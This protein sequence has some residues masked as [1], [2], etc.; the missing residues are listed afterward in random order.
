M[1]VDFELYAFLTECGEIQNKKSLKIKNTKS[2]MLSSE[3]VEKFKNAEMNN[4]II[5]MDN[6][7]GK[8]YKSDYNYAS[9]LSELKND[10]KS[11][12][13]TRLYNWKILANVLGCFGL[14]VEEDQYLKI[15]GGNYI[16]L[17]EVLTTIYNFCSELSKR[18]N[19]LNIDK[20]TD[21]SII[22]TEKINTKIDEIQEKNKKI[23]TT[24]NTYIQHT[25]NL[26]NTSN[27]RR[28]EN[29]VIE[30]N[31]LNENKDIL[32]SES[33]LEYF[34]LS[35]CKS[36]NIKIRQAAG[37]LS[38]NRKFLIQ[39]CNKG[40]KGDYSKL[41]NWYTILNKTTHCLLVLIKLSK[42]DAK[43]M[44]YAT[45]SCGLYSK[46][47]AIA[48]NALNLLNYL[49]ESTEPET[50][51]FFKE[52]LNSYL[53][54]INY[55][56][57]S[58]LVK[59][60]NS[61]E[62]YSK[63]NLQH[64][65]NEIESKFKN[66]K[67]NLYNF[68]ENI[69]EKI[70]CC[71]DNT[72]NIFKKFIFNNT[73]D[74]N[75]EDKARLISIMSD[76]WILHYNSDIPLN[77]K[78][79]IKDNLLECLNINNPLN[80]NIN[81]YNSKIVQSVA[82][83]Q[84]FRLISF[85]G[86]KKDPNAPELLKSVN[87]KLI[88]NFK[89]DYLREQLL[90]NLSIIFEQNKLIPVDI[91]FIDYI[92]EA[93]SLENLDKLKLFDFKFI[94]KM[95][96]H[97]RFISE[98][99][100]NLYLDDLIVILFSQFSKNKDYGRICLEKFVVLIDL[101]YISESNSARLEKIV[102]DSLKLF[103]N[104]L[105]NPSLLYFAY[106]IINMQI[107]K[108]NIKLE[109][110]IIEANKKYRLEQGKYS[111]A[112]LSLLWFYDKYDDLIMELEE[113]SAKSYDHIIDTKVKHKNS[114]KKKEIVNKPNEYLM[115]VKQ[116]KTIENQIQ[117]FKDKEKE[118]KKLEN[119]NKLQSTLKERALELGTS[120][121]IF[122]DIYKENLNKLVSNI[123]AIKD[124]QCNDEEKQEKIGDNINVGE[125]IIDIKNLDINDNNIFSAK[126]LT[127]NNIFKHPTIRNE[128]T[129]F[130]YA[131][132]TNYD[133][134]TGLY[135]IDFDLEEDCELKA[136]SCLI[137]QNIK[138]INYYYN[139]Y[140]F[141]TKTKVINKINIIRML[142]DLG[143]SNT[144]FNTEE[145]FNITRIEY[146]KRIEVFN[147]E[148]FKKLLIYISKTIFSKINNTKQ[149]YSYLSTFLELLII[150]KITETNKI[151]EEIRAD[152]L[153][154][155]QFVDINNKDDINSFKE[156]LPLGFKL[157]SNK[158]LNVLHTVNFKDSGIAVK[159]CL[160]I[161][162]NNKNS[163]IKSK[164]RQDFHLRFLKES[165][166][167][168]LEIINDIVYKITEKNI[169]E[170]YVD[171]KNEYDI[172]ILNNKVPNWNK[173]VLLAS[174]YI[175]SKT[176]EDELIIRDVGNLVNEML[177]SLA[178]GYTSLCKV[179]PP[180]GIEKTYIECL[181]KFQIEDIEKEKQRK[182][183]NQYLKEELI[184]LKAKNEEIKKKEKE[185]IIK[186]K[187]EK[188][189]I[190]KQLYLKQK[191][192]KEKLKQLIRDKNKQ[193]KEEE[194]KKIR[195]D[196]DYEERK[197]KMLKEKEKVFL[198]KQRLLFKKQFK[199]LKDRY[200]LMEKAYEEVYGIKYVLKSNSQSN[201][202]NK[203]I[204]DKSLIKNNISYNDNKIFKIFNKNKTLY[205]FNSNL[206][207]IIEKKIDNNHKNI[208]SV[209]DK[210]SLHIDV[211]FNI[212]SKISINKLGLIYNDVINFYGLKEFCHDLLLL[213]LCLSPNQLKFV[214]KK[215]S[216]RNE[217]EKEDR[218]F[219]KNIKDFKLAIAY[220]IIITK[221]LPKKSIDINKKHIDRLDDIAVSSFFDFTGLNKYD[222]KIE[223]ENFINNRRAISEKDRLE[224]INNL[225]LNSLI[226]YKDNIYLRKTIKHKSY[227]AANNSQDKRTI[228]KSKDINKNINKDISIKENTEKI[229][230]DKNNKN[231]ADNHL[232]Q[233]NTSTKKSKKI[234]SEKTIEIKN[235]QG[236][237]ETWD[238]K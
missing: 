169:I 228:L 20:K 190:I 23:P 182:L 135:K 65:I 222:K 202:N 156:L 15:I 201:L 144:L 76:M 22:N 64:L 104:R 44:T 227:I 210:F 148:E 118:N 211:L 129:V 116:K 28:G 115:Y 74:A 146:G 40:L 197:Q 172:V 181:N 158:L 209:F 39:V 69:I 170:P 30:L 77:I 80:I 134:Y 175:K 9:K 157:I 4:V 171:I 174:S 58:L 95:I 55:H 139:K 27:L 75:I 12:N 34:L 109:P 91:V 133:I 67:N 89:D 99:N 188:D 138:K 63:L 46:S 238:I 32:K 219:L 54:A 1:E 87:K 51:W 5:K 122:E 108:I 119:Y 105:N 45:V 204:Y 26:E 52:G 200:N 123:K 164:N 124:N 14:D 218:F 113:K 17:K 236:K 53:F 167:I 106:E 143:I 120:K 24:N 131:K 33:I 233:Q 132:S 8:Y 234:D 150:P 90:Y 185:E 207:N 136:I 229:S 16:A 195:E 184:K 230:N 21:S 82:I 110:L 10:E 125:D 71:N 214:F 161:N 213:G 196:R 94:D 162:Q 19:Y 137:N 225:K 130:K 85:L 48:E 29:N 177:K 81:N 149:L 107:Q 142:R 93:K 168:S 194:V 92:K 208:G 86:E 112:L 198:K 235:P 154:K 192:E 36:L 79:K 18:S 141:D 220:I 232:I 126:I 57:D 166:L 7:Y 42:N 114:K 237:K 173:S 66:N 206:N 179:K 127:N 187:K 147:F 62:S 183:R 152:Y 176:I 216:K 70:N 97:P 60:L 37:L 84:I 111:V 121:K 61:M 101:D 191:E 103:K 231:N 221:Y 155:L 180:I 226:A 223:I 117:K 153:K 151:T 78:N 102:I 193:K 96:K 35:L 163:F 25:K 72:F 212:Y 160:Q 165:Q 50:D 215:I 189:N 98:N 56:H 83:I 100:N 38:D 43:S 11:T 31:S 199:S 47:K 59:C 6:I 186:I 205:E 68:I 2:I 3:V 178:I 41:E 224:L 13:S 128:D 49:I 88:I 217:G 145:L 73:I 140:L 159:T 203:E